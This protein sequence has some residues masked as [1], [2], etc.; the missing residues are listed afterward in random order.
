[1]SNAGKTLIKKIFSWALVK[2]SGD[3]TI[4]ESNYPSKYLGV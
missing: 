4:D 2:G 3:V 1:M